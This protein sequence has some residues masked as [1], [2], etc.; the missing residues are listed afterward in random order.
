MAVKIRLRRAGSNKRPFYRVV[1]ADARHPI[2]GK[3]IELVG[4]YDP[5]KSGVNYQLKMDRVE[6]W[7]NNGA[8]VSD[9]VNSIIK[10]ARAGSASSPGTATAS[11]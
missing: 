5:K 11:S 1:V 3:F 6:Y 10:K 9:T 2:K 8:Q 7:L 4:W